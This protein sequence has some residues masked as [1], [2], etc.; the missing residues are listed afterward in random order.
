[1]RPLNDAVV[2][3][4]DVAH[5]RH[6]EA[7]RPQPAVENVEGDEHAR[8]A[9]VAPVVDGDAAHVDADLARGERLERLDAAGQSVVERERYL[10]S[11]E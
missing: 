7:A 4:G 9:D 6:L 1:L 11:P 3:V 8:V 2:D 10:S 5:E